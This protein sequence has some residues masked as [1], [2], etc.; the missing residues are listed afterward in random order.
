MIQLVKPAYAAIS[1]PFLKN[2]SDIV[3]N[4]Q[5]YVNNIIQTIISVFFIVA[6]VYFI[7]HFVMAGYHM[8]N[9]N[10]DPKKWEEA[11]KAIL[12]GL[13]GLILVFSLFAILKFAG[14]VLGIPGLQSLQLIW[15]S[16]SN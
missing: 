16:L 10:G 3:S 6:V 1:N 9:S 7:W 4:P 8:I 12:Y 2:S 14:T 15:P 13:V 11:Q 5:N